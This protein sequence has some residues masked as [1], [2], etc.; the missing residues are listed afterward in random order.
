MAIKNTTQHKNTQRTTSQHTTG[1]HRVRLASAHHGC[2]DA[3]TCPSPAGVA[4]RL[5]GA[6]TITHSNCQTAAAASAAAATAPV[7]DTS[8]TTQ[9]TDAQKHA[10][11]S[12]QCSLIL[13][14]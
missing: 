9:C 4:K 13:T 7:L 3:S 6:A 12:Y 1:R 5:P 10:V 8:S 11:Y 14:T 2:H